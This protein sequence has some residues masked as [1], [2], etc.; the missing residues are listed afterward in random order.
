M[1][2]NLEKEKDNEFKKYKRCLDAGL[3]KEYSRGFRGGFAPI[4]KFFDGTIYFRNISSQGE[5]WLKL[6]LDLFNVSFLFTASN[7]VVLNFPQFLDIW[8][9]VLPVAIVCWVI[10]VFTLGRIID[11]RYTP[12]KAQRNFDNARN[13]AMQRIE[14]SL[15]KIVKQLKKE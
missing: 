3:E 14:G 2:K 13:P 10:S 6:P 7:Y 11:K 5:A 15:A 4:Q 12:L 8:N 9:S 1:P